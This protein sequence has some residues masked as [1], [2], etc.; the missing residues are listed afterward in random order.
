MICKLV[1]II[2]SYIVI[3]KLLGTSCPGYELSWVRV[4]LGTSCLGYESSWVRVVLGTSCPGYELSWVRVVLGTSCLGYELSIIP[5]P[6][7]LQAYMA[8][9]AERWRGRPFPWSPSSRHGNKRYKP[10][11]T[12]AL[13]DCSFQSA[14]NDRQTHPPSTYV[15]IK[16]RLIINVHTLDTLSHGNALGSSHISSWCLSWCTWIGSYNDGCNFWNDKHFIRWSSTSS[17]IRLTP[18]NVLYICVFS[19]I[20]LEIKLLL[21]PAIV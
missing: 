19:C 7:P 15:W 9:Q 2:F 5:H 14:G 16:V 17:D 3:A 20:L 4:I 13:G 21:T 8:K 10:S 1:S 18:V 12:K 6:V 11:Y